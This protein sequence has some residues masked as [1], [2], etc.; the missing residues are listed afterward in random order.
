MPRDL[1]VLFAKFPRPGRVK[2]RLARAIG[3]DAAAKLYEGFLIDLIDRHLRQEYELVVAVDPDTGTPTE[4]RHRFEGV[5]AVRQFGRDLGERLQETFCRWTRP[6]RKVVIIGSDMPQLRPAAVQGALDALSECDVSIGPC[7]DGGFYLL[8]MKQ[9]HRILDG[10]SWSTPKVLEQV[11]VNCKGL[12]VTSLPPARDI[13]TG[14]DLM[15][16]LPELQS[17]ETPATAKLLGSID[18]TPVASEVNH[19]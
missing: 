19:D 3:I 2:T 13:D 16:S 10:V 1:L 11:L 17:S 5:H 9:P 12:R 8:G 6:A 15:A 4:F 14:D 7:I 18:L